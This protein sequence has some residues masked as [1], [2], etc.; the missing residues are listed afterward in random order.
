MQQPLFGYAFSG[1]FFRK[2]RARHPFPVYG[3]HLV[4]YA[5]IFRSAL[6]DM[7]GLTEVYYVLC[8]RNERSPYVEYMSRKPGI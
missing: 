4:M 3:M 7:D 6:L 2:F 1:A 8:F 5:G